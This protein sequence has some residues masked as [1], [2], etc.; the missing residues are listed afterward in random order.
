MTGP[1]TL[2]AVESPA[3]GFALLERAMGYTLGSLVL[4]TPGAMTGATPCTRWDL[5]ALLRH[6]NDSLQTLHEAIACGH[7]ELDTDPGADYGDVESDPVASLR[8]RA[9]QMIGAWAREP[10]PTDISV[11]DA[12]MPAGLVAATG[13][14]EVAV[15]GWD[16][17]QS[18]G[19]VRPVPAGLAHELLLLS[20]VLVDDTDRPYRF[21]RPVDVRPDAGP[22]DRLLAYLGR[23]PG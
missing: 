20:Q 2:S 9:C 10:A 19:V 7:L 1:L 8:G 22:S 21:G 13:A 14:I 15:H 16:V 4:V 6:M 5:R 17:A 12:Q 11:A 18:C 23:D 3:G